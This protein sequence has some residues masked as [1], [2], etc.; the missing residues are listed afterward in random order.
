LIFW[1]AYVPAAQFLDSL[2]L[3]S[4]A[5]TKDMGSNAAA[6]GPAPFSGADSPLKNLGWAHM[7]CIICLEYMRG[8]IQQQNSIQVHKW[9]LY[10]VHTPHH[11]KTR[12]Y[13]YTHIQTQSHTHT[14]T[15]IHVHMH[16]TVWVWPVPVR[17]LRRAP[18]GPSFALP[19]ASPSPA[20]MK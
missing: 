14:V 5:S 10:V 6:L 11:S 19:S 18:R 9:V 8:E 7:Y 12:T 16:S 20:Y 3:M 15:L 4:T 17:C 1:S 2:V 13:T